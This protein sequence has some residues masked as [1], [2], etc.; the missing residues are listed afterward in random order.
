[1]ST[2]VELDVP[3]RAEYVRVV[4]MV[5]AALAAT[6]R[7]LDEDRIDDLRLAVSEACALAVGA[8]ERLRV[9]AREEPD[10]FVVDV[11]D[12]PDDV[13]ADELAFAIIS[14]LVDDVAPIDGGLRLRMACL[15]A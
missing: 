15:P 12:R 11:H 6:T 7:D 10:A 13:E 9:V 8:G 3:A 2:P 14:A 4:R 1:M 5:V